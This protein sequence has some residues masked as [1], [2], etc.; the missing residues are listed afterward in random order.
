MKR[1]T[2]LLVLCPFLLLAGFT[3]SAHATTPTS[4]PFD[5]SF[6]FVDPTLCS[7][8]VQAQVHF[9]GTESPAFSPL[10][11]AG[12][13]SLSSNGNVVSSLP[14]NSF[15]EMDFTQV[16][17]A[18]TYDLKASGAINV[19]AGTGG[20]GGENVTATIVPE[21]LEVSVIALAAAHLC[22]RRRRR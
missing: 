16:L 7:F 13:A 18:G 20:N 19:A 17:D 21:P 5:Q 4:E 1:V 3:G 15:G 11:F 14:F 22:A 9:V 10:Y 6:G 12:S 2:A 8:P